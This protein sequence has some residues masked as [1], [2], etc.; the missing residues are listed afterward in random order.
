MSNEGK[1]VDA[2]TIRFERLL[3]APIERVWAYLV[4]PA[5]RAEWF[6][7]GAEFK[8]P[9]EAQLLFNHAK[10]TT[11]D[12]KPPRQY[13]QYAGEVQA[14][15]KIVEIEP[16]R[17]L[18]WEWQDEDGK[19]LTTR[20]ELTARGNKVLL[21]LTESNLASAKAVIGNSSGWQ[22]HVDLLEARLAGKTPPP[23][24]ATLM[25]HRA[26]YEKKLASR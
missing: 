11:P 16:P 17:L 6:A 12:D 5:K 9:G 7:G 25:A 18:V 10:L 19:P 14:G 8:T 24:W 3:P 21:T 1:M 23:F 22:V 4:D 2:T 26:K 13:E 20:F 15:V